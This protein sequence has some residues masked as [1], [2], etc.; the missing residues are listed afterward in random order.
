[1]EEE[2]EEGIGAGAGIVRK[3][4]WGFGNEARTEGEGAKIG[5][6]GGL[7]LAEDG[8]GGGGFLLAEEEEEKVANKERTS[9]RPVLAQR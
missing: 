4:A 9:M 3:V 2:E 6:G 7:V 8:T 5:R 1:M